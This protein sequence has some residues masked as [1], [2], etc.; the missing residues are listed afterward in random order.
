MAATVSGGWNV[1]LRNRNFK[2]GDHILFFEYD[3]FI[4][5][6]AVNF[7]RLSVTWD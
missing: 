4:P 6:N 1:V 5:T 7:A 3:S 2:V